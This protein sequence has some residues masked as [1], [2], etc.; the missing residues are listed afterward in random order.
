M[1]TIQRFPV[2][3]EYLSSG[4]HPKLCTVLN[5]ITCTNLAGNIVKTYYETSHDFCGQRI[6]ET[7]VCDT[8][9]ARG[10]MRLEE[11]KAKG[12]K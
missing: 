7:D 4:K 2:C 12:N 3:T 5:F 1:Q 11:S 10:V 8:T 9:I 6:V